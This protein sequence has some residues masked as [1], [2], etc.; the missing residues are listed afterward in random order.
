MRSDTN[1]IGFRMQM[2]QLSLTKGLISHVVKRTQSQNNDPL[3]QAGDTPTIFSVITHQ[4]CLPISEHAFERNSIILSPTTGTILFKSKEQIE[5]YTTDRQR[6]IALKEVGKGR[7][8][9]ELEGMGKEYT[10]WRKTLKV[11]TG[12]YDF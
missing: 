11:I 8:V 3:P 12:L 7:L 9:N 6:K 1:F 5:L 2:A 10:K 4:T